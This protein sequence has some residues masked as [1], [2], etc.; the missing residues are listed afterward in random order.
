MIRETLYA[1]LLIGAGVVTAAWM[2]FL[3][4]AAAGMFIYGL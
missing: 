1:T 4:W 2:G 3:V